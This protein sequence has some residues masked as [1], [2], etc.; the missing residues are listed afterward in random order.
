MLQSYAKV[1]HVSAQFSAYLADISSWTA[2]HQPKFNPSRSELL[3]IQ[4]DSFPRQNLV[5]S[6]DNSL[7]TPSVTARSCEL[8]VDNRLSSSSHIANLTRSC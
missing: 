2:A 3:F 1:T 5:I 7:I 6:L 4:G 8:T